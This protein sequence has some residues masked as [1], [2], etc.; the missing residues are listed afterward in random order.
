MVDQENV[1]GGPLDRRGDAM[2]VLVAENEGPENQQVER[3]LQQLD[4]IGIGHSGRQ[5]TRVLGDCLLEGYVITG[6]PF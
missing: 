1:F 6:R 5:T 4:T 2:T 3:A